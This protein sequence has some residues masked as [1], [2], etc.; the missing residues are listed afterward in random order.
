LLSGHCVDCYYYGKTCAFGR[1]RVAALFFKRGK[2]KFSDIKLTWASLAPDFFVS[3][4]PLVAGAIL[5][6]QSFDWI[7]AALVVAIL[8]L[9]SAGNA[10]CRGKIACAHCKQRALGCP[11]EKLFAKK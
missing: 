9:T 7:L 8:V 3:L 2:K 5:L 4:I 1:G 6:W 10:F 11:A